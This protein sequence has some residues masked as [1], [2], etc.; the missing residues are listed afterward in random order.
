MTRRVT[1]REA[2]G[3]VAAVY[4]QI[5]EEFALVSPMMLHSPAPEILAGVWC[6]SREAFVV[7]KAGLA[8]GDGSSWRSAQGL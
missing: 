2:K 6:L 5:A 8:R 3:L 1:R 7:N 4:D